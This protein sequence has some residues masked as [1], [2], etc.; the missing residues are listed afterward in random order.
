MSDLNQIEQAACDMAIA[1]GKR[2][3]EGEYH[4]MLLR[5]T[6]LALLKGVSIESCVAKAQRRARESERAHAAEA[7]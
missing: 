1:C 4:V 5:N 7:A 6:V 2:E 3:L